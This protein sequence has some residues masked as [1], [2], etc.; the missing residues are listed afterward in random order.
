MASHD[1]PQHEHLL[2]LLAQQNSEHGTLLLDLDCRIFWANPAAERILG[3]SLDA[4]RDQPFAMLFTPQDRELGVPDVE[5]AI[6]RSGGTAEDD[7]WQQRPDGSRFWASGALV[8]LYDHGKLAA[9]GK[10]FRNRSDLRLQIETLQR[11]LAAQ[12]DAERNRVSEL[13]MLAHELRNPLTPMMTTCHL[14]RALDGTPQIQRAAE[15]FEHQIQTLGRTIDDIPQTVAQP[16]TA[17]FRTE[18]LALNALLREVVE[19]HR[20]EAQACDQRLD[21]L[22][23]SDDLYVD[24]D[25]DRLRQVFENL[26]SNALKFTPGGGQIWIKLTTEHDECV[27]RVEDTG[28]GLAPDQFDRIFELFARAEPT[29]STPGSGV[30][31]AVVKLWVERHGGSVQVESDG[32]QTGCKFTVRLPKAR[33]DR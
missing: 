10:I 20:A 26:L 13:R 28:V 19:M 29:A 6:A 1:L 18:P 7:R 4:L 22:V 5:L 33:A 25:I 27:A 9:F 24:G 16:G 21:L 8:P 3:A 31:L 23:P 32:P 15:L 17:A 2:L 30:G 11:R 14:L 12:L